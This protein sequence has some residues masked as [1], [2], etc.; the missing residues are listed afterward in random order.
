VQY[1]LLNK[2]YGVVCQFTKGPEAE[3][4]LA[5]YITVPG[6]YPVG[7]LDHDSEGLVL[8]TDDGQLQHVLTD[9]KFGHGKT[10]LAQVE[11]VPTAEAL[12]TLRNGVL[13]K[14]FKTR[15]A[16]RPAKARLLDREP[17]LW[18]RVP[19]IRYRA[20]IPTSWIE[21][22]LEEG[23]NRQ[24]RRMTAK[25][26]FPTLRLVRTAIGD[27]SVAGLAPGKSRSLTA[28]E[29]ARLLRLGESS[30]RVRRRRHG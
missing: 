7:R 1:L 22:E 2:P 6:V 16:T 28:T 11:G 12:E 26:G 10:Y 15:Y 29:L 9:P 19:P 8:L 5:D 27:L 4:T 17:E 21:I 13:L 18:A 24:V 20:A 30:L 23:R 3:A 14:G 25:V